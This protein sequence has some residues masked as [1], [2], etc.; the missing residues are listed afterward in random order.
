MKSG[1]EKAVDAVG[2]QAKLAA[3]LGVSAAIVS[4]WV[5]RGWVSNNIAVR[6]EDELGIPRAETLDPSLL[7]LVR[8]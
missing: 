6:L 8:G 4:R 1:I 3:L 2:N 7:A 5:K